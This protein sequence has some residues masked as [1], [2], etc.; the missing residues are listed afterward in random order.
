MIKNISVYCAASNRMDSLYFTNAEKLGRLLGQRRF[1]VI[2]G[3][4][5]IGLM[6]A[7][8]DTVLSAGGTVT[9]VIPQFMVEKG[10]CHANLTT[11]IQTQ[12]MHERKKTM[13][14]L[15]DATIA[16]PGGFGTME[17]LL[18]IITW[19]QLGLYNNPIIILNINNFYNPLLEM[20]SRSV[21][22]KFVREQ[23]DCLWDV[24]NT[25]DE[26]I[27]LLDKE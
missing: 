8:T 11:V 10:L 14:D 13:A 17:E 16:L 12:T 15:S 20:F 26:V 6:R 3:A 9:G 22:E 24:A 19:R 2:N 5:N 4:G 25:P 18:E 27:E 1:H 7:I 21:A 23:H